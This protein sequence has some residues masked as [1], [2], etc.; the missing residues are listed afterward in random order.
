MPAAA[1]AKLAF[2]GQIMLISCTLSSILYRGHA[3]SLIL[4]YL[5]ISLSAN[6]CEI[7]QDEKTKPGYPAYTRLLAV[8]YL[9]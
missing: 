5:D 8:A 3:Q 6:L 1:A 9:L 7:T 2:F 4:S